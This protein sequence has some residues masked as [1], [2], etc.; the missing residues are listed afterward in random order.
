[1]P[2]EDQMC[3]LPPNNPLQRSVN[4][5]V[6]GRGRERALPEQVTSARVLERPR[7]AAERGRY[8]SGSQDSKRGLAR[9]L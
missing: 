8:I 2:L 4:D 6:L 7:P 1:M 5:K 3:C 9:L